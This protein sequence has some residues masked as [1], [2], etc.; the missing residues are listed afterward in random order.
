MAPPTV[1]LSRLAIRM[2]RSRSGWAAPTRASVTPADAVTW[3]ASR[4]TG[5]SSVSRARLSTT[6]PCSGTPPP[7]S[8]VL[9]PWGTTARPARVQQASTAATC[10]V[11]AGRT[12]AGGPALEAAGPV[13][14][15]PGG[16]VAGQDV[17][18][19]DDAGQLG[20]DRGSQ[21]RWH[22]LRVAFPGGVRVRRIK[23]LGSVARPHGPRE[24][25]A[26]LAVVAEDPEA[27]RGGGQQ[28]DPVRPG[29]VE[30][31]PARPRRG[32]RTA[33][34]PARPARRP[35]RVLVRPVLVRAP[36]ASRDSMA[37]WMRGPL[38]GS[39]STSVGAG[40]AR[41]ASP[42]ASGA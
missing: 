5:L 29:P 6:S 13:D 12:T 32:R 11:S 40:P 36:L 4:S 28:H 34:R 18:A 21:F 24:G 17:R 38:S 39:V 41:G 20:L 14:G 9:P 15:E 25:L 33:A 27:R 19:A 7:T 22:E 3:R 2:P 31:R 35:G 42:A 8:P 37:A 1:A 23:P 16:R 30:A 26:P 10:S